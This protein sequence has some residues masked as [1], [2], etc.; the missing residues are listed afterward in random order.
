MSGPKQALCFVHSIYSWLKMSKT[1]WDTDL[2]SGFLKWRYY[3]QRKGKIIP[4]HHAMKTYGGVK[5]WFHY[6]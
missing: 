6:S 5:A 2:H 4:V 3:G 1:F